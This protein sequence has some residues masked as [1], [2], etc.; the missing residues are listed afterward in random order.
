MAE[1]R[2]SA[3]RGS[4]LLLI[5]AAVLIVVILASLAVDQAVVFGAQRD[6]VATAQAAANDAAAVGI[7]PDAV[8]A[9]S[10]LAY[11]DSRID[12]AVRAAAAR[13]D[14]QVV[15]SW[16]RHGTVIVVRLRRRVA[17]I[18]ARAV[19]GASRG[20]VVTAEASAELLVA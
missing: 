4:V 1:G 11:D 14:G 7:D 9:G 5:P 3:E 17:R 8:R 13:A 20:V 12:R 19:P 10:G 15:A 18:F 16:E 2:R 6:L